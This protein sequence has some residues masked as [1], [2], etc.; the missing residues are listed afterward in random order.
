[1]RCRIT[2]PKTLAR[3]S[4]LLNM[5]V[6]AAVT[7]GGTDHRID[8]RTDKGLGFSLFRDGSIERC[9]EMD[10]KEKASETQVHST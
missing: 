5:T 9:P 7:R 2:N 1:M 3:L 8:V 6:T 10:K 4:R